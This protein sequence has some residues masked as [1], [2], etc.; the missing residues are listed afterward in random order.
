MSIKND[1]PVAVVV[2]DEACLGPAMLKLTERQ[3]KFV[4]AM[5]EL[6]GVGHA[7]A[8]ISA[9]Y[10]YNPDKPNKIEVQAYCLAHD[11][12]IQDAIKEVG[13]RMLNAGAIL[14]VKTVLEIADNPQAEMKDRLKAAEMIMNRTGL[15]ALTEHKATVV[16]KTEKTADMVRFV[17][18]MAGKLGLDPVK[19]IGNCVIEGDFEEMPEDDLSDIYG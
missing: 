11:E 9:G 6:G 7:R 18:T 2:P 4:M 1:T 10:S 15:H 17:E 3:Q 5:I 14:A 13:I 8:A 16:H 19:L 12:K